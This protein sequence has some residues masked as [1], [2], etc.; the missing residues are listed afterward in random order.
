MK[1]IL[2]LLIALLLTPV[3]ASAE[4]INLIELRNRPAEEIIPIITPMLDS[5][6]SISG[7]GF[8]LFIRTSDENLAQIRSLIDQLDTAAKQ[9]L[10]SVFQGSDRE[11]RALRLSG[12]IQHDGGEIDIQAG[13]PFPRD[14][15]AS[16]Q[17]GTGDT[18]VNVGAASTRARL[19]DNPVHSLRVTEGSEAYIETGQSIPYYS[20]GVYRTPYGRAVD[21]DVEFKDVTTG[22]YVYPRVHGDQVTLDVSPFKG[23]LNR[24]RADTINT[25]RVTTTVTGRLGEWLQLG[26]V[27]EQVK[28]SGTGIGSYASTQDRNAASIW[29]KAE[30]SP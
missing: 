17:Y 22:F 30:L 14:G 25:Q 5:G 19:S 21:T 26:G 29:I 1:R 13:K 16:V 9:L 20:G 6:A 18:R 27:N 2:L 10:I 15:G 11:L 7:Q 24:S 8:T 28:R 23:S 4:A 3:P 12:G